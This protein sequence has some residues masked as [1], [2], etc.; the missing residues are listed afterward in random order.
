MSTVRSVAMPSSSDS[1]EP[2]PW[3]VVPSSTYVTYGEAIGSPSSSLSTEA[4]RA[5][6]IAS[7]RWPSASWKT[8]PP[9]PL[10]RTTGIV[11]A[12]AG[13]ARRLTRA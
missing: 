8:T 4:R 6:E 5:T 3:G 9:Q 10:P 11:P 2:Q 7:T 12:G 1:D 13:R